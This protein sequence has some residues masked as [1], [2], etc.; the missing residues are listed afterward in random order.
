MRPLLIK[1]QRG[2]TLVEIAVISPILILVTVGLI[3]GLILIANNVSGPNRQNSLIR[4]TQRALD[5]IEKDV[6]NSSN[7]LTSVTTTDN[8]DYY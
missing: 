3:A 8:T 5:M 2:F 6:I 7:F 1:N 4:S